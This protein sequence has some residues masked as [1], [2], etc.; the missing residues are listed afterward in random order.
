MRAFGVGGRPTQA[1]WAGA[2][3]GGGFNR[4]GN[5][6]QEFPSFQEAAKGKW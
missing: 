5:L 2:G 6:D 3:R 4:G 1:P